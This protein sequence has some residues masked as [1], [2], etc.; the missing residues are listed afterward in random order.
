MLIYFI[1]G[2]IAGVACSAYFIGKELFSIHRKN[3]LQEKQL[4]RMRKLNHQL[5]TK[6]ALITP[7]KQSTYVNEKGNL[8]SQ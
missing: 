5:S 3:T 4:D 8:V 7:N 1:S 6:I 2:S